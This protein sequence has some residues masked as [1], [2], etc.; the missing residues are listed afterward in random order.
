MALKQPGSPVKKHLCYF[1]SQRRSGRK[2]SCSF[3]SQRW[4]AGLDCNW[5]SK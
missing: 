5:R 1:Q 2:H 4:N 3:C